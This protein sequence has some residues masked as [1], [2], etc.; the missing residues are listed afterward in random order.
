MRFMAVNNYRIAMKEFAKKR[1]FHF[2]K[3][4]QAL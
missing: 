3:S 1:D 4:L 2:R